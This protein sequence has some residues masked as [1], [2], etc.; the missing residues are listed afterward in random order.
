MGVIHN[1]HH[2]LA[3]GSDETSQPIKVPARATKVSIDLNPSSSFS[4][5]S[6]V[7]TLQHA[8][9]PL[10]DHEN[11]VAL[12][13]TVTFTNST[14]TQVGISVSGLEYIRLKTTTE[15]GTADP[16]AKLIV[17]FNNPGGLL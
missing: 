17:R 7:V 8:L 12:E 10:G 9:S 15:D 14:K 4:G 16:A 6:W 5:T 11:W 2:N 13:K 1:L 3:A